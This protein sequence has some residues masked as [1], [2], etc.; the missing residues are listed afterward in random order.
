M[1]ARE[2]SPASEQGLVDFADVPWRQLR[3]L[4][5]ASS[6]KHPLVV[7]YQQGSRFDAKQQEPCLQAQD[8]RHAC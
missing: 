2:P 1:S 7:L 6:A 3:Q 8:H 5:Y 4:E